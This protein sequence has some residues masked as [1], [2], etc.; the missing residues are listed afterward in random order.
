MKLLKT[1]KTFKKEI[2][3]N[4]N[5]AAI[6]NIIT[7]FWTMKNN[8]FEYPGQS[9]PIICLL[10]KNSPFKVFDLFLKKIQI[11][12]QVVLFCIYQ[13]G[14]SVKIVHFIIIIFQKPV[15]SFMLVGSLSHFWH[16]IQSQNQLLSYFHMMSLYSEQ[17]EFTNTQAKKWL[18]TMNKFNHHHRIPNNCTSWGWDDDDDD[19][20]LSP[21]MRLVTLLLLLHIYVLVRAIYNTQKY[22]HIISLMLAHDGIIWIV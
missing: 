15:S 2:Y 17:Y 18:S 9:W 3:N 11:N 10:T 14:W 20:L 5:L 16:G 8:I 1:W 13:N 4:K 21:W 19:A 22:M 7:S 12:T 6:Q